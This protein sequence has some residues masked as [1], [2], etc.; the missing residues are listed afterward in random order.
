M[1]IVLIGRIKLYVLL[2]HGGQGREKIR[3]EE[4][5]EKQK[6]KLGFN[7]KNK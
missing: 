7:W 6:R 3:E 1:I 2:R 4:M 5:R